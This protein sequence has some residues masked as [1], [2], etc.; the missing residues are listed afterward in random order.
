MK[1]EI[2]EEDVIEEEEEITDFESAMVME[3]LGFG[4][5]VSD[6]QNKTA[7]FLPKQKEIKIDEKKAKEESKE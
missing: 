2:K 1:E 5:F 4:P 6:T 7:N 3:A